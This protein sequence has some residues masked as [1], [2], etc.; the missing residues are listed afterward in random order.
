MTQV[1]LSAIIVNWNG[2]RYLPECLAMLMPQLPPGGELVLVDNGSTDGSLAFVREHSPTARV[3]ALRSNLG[4]AGGV[5][6]GLR[7]AQGELLLLL[8]NDAFVEPGFVAALLGALDQHPEA[9]AAGA[10]LAF[11]HRPDL[12]ASAGIRVRR[13][14]LALDLWPGRPVAELLQ[15]PQPIFG[16]SG[17]AALY[18]RALLED[19]GLMQPGFFSYLEDADLA[20][21]AQLRGWCS[22]VAPGA[23]ARHV[24]SAT[25]GQGSPF[26]QRL[27]GRN[28]LLTILRCL[29]GPLLRSCLPQILAYDL[30][31]LA[32]GLLGRQPAIV[33]GRMAALRELPALLAE[34][35]AIQARRSAPLADLARWLEPA[36]PPWHALREQ[37]RLDAILSE[38]LEI[39]E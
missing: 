9:G 10:V 17:G 23:R 11:A 39:G 18:R 25:G 8:N 19:V 20:W 22:V 24:Y 28:R 5:N 12:V 7:A 6:A 29:P 33:A 37:R 26:K 14:G 21:R 3:V 36:G 2:L 35:R 15:A 38:R 34:R 27:L 1:P 13:D 31:A 4:F 30:L 16:P 32:Y